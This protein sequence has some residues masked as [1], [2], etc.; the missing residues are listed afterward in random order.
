MAG[1]AWDV[2][3]EPATA[4]GHW[5]PDNVGAAAPGVLTPLSWSIWRTVGDRAPREVAYRLGAFSGRDRRDFPD[6]V[7]PFYGRIAI[8]MEFVGPFGDRIPRVTGEEAVRSLCG[9]V[10]ETMN[11]NPT[12]A[13]YPPLA[14]TLPPP[15]FM[16]PPGIPT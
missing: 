13:P 11:F 2:L 3:H 1:E 9:R 4:D 12:P 5:S 10:P 16:T 6:I 14:G 15:Q 7:R 8:R